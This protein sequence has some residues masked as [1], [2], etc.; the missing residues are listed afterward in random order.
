MLT[1]WANTSEVARALGVYSKAVSFV[2]TPAREHD[3]HTSS[4][5]F[6][7]LLISEERPFALIRVSV[8]FGKAKSIEVRL[9]DSP[10]EQAFWCRS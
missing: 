6:S 3:A 8:N 10:Q 7:W 5:A 9:G 2:P 1:R 4:G